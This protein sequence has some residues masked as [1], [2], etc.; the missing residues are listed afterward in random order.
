MNR[1]VKCFRT[2]VGWISLAVAFLPIISLIVSFMLLGGSAPE[3][4]G[5]P[6]DES[7]GMSILMLLAL[8]IG[9]LILAIKLAA[10]LG[11]VMGWYYGWL[12][13]I[14]E[15]NFVLFFVGIAMILSILTSDFSVEG[16]IKVVI[17]LSCLV[18]NIKLK[19]LWLGL[20]VRERFDVARAT[21]SEYS[22]AG[23]V[24]K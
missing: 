11:N 16:G 15:L 4:K 5:A 19:A 1:L 9:V 2:K 14:L 10:V 18:I 12:L 21:H 3:S 13:H 22:G 7:A 6:I 24:D 23:F 20:E 17:G 8:S